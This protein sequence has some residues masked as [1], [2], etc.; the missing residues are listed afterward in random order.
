MAKEVASAPHKIAVIGYGNVGWHLAQLFK[1]RLGWIVSRTLG[2]YEK[3]KVVRRW[4]ALPDD[5]PLIIFLTL[6]DRLISS[7]AKQM[8][9]RSWHKDTIVVHCAGMVPLNALDGKLPNRA[10][11]YPLASLVK[12]LSNEL[13]YEHLYVLCHTEDE[14]VFNTLETITEETGKKI[15][16]IRTN[17][18]IRA[19]YHLCATVSHNFANFLWAK[20]HQWLE[21]N[22]MPFNPIAWLIIKNFTNAL[23]K[24]SPAEVQTG[25]AVRRDEITIH[26]HIDLLERLDPDFIPVYKL[27]TKA[28]QDNFP[29]NQEEDS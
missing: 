8:A 27:L 26:Q 14:N 21:T 13:L 10:V 28:I 19:C 12:G 25:P 29:L 1:D 11:W 18:V 23:I 22:D 6:P 17:D 16:L 3:A 7:Y 4:E 5:I 2:E 9:K 20:A 15:N 24:N